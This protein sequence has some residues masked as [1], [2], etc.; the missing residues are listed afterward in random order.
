M[1]TMESRHWLAKQNVA[2]KLAMSARSRHHA[3]AC[4]NCKLEEQ[5]CQELDLNLT[6][7]TMTATI[8]NYSGCSNYCKFLLV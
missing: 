4:H 2:S 6:R 1:A 3:W 7:V 5:A 8:Y